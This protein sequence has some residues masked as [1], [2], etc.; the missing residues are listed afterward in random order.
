MGRRGR[1]TGSGI[2]ARIQSADR[3]SPPASERA[4]S[5]NRLIYGDNLAILQDTNLLPSHSVD[6]IYLDP[7]FNSDVEYNV[8]F[9][10]AGST[11][12]AAQIKAFDDTW[13]WDEA[14]RAALDALLEDALTPPAL[15]GLVSTLHRTLGPSPM[16]AYLVQMAARL[17]HL[18]RVLRPTGSIFLHCDPT[19]SHYL[20]VLLDT[21]FGPAMFTNE[22]VWRRT[23]SHNSSKCLGRIHDIIL[24]YKA[25]PTAVFNRVSRPYMRGHVSRRYTVQPDGRAKFTSGGNILTG[26]GATR[27]ESG[28]AWRGFAPAAKNR[29]WAIPARSE[30]GMPPEYYQLGTLDRLEAL[31][32]CGRIEIL[33]GQAWP[34]P[35]WYLDDRDGQALQDIW[36]AQPYTEGTVWNT[37][38]IID[39]DVSWLGTTDPERLGYPTQKP[40]GL[41]KR[42]IRLASNPGATILDPF[43]G[44]GTTIDAV[45]VLNREDPN[46][47]PR[48]W[49][50]IDIT[51]LAINLIKSRLTRFVPAA[52]YDVLGEPTDLAGAIQ[53]FKDDPFQFQYWAA[54]LVGARPFGAT[55]AAPK[56]GKKGADRGVD[57]VRH[58]VDA[59]IQHVLVQVKGGRVG[60]KDARDLRGTLAR[61]NAA[62]GI[63]IC[64]KEPTKA[65]R[66]EAASAGSYRSRL[67]EDISVPRLQIV[68]VAQLL[69]GGSPRVPNG[70]QLPPAACVGDRTFRR[71]VRADGATLFDGTQRRGGEDG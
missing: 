53:L 42:I 68:T 37:E 7:P 54:G 60:S 63:L 27:G 35:V 18:Q 33:P 13:R 20:K 62:I 57:A 25:S 21:I 8:L 4:Q 41:L 49:I 38:D 3:S 48:R 16:L 45:E 14:A 69:A 52:H 59:E 40:I 32:K 9:R 17:T 36:A 50:G 22:I 44:C 2:K 66:Q 26:P 67:D 46:S 11:E 28:A 12:A 61:E 70:I 55:T 6:L 19:A 34:Q 5:G 31:Y 47:T 1:S 56:V 71:A 64:L 30:E 58:F 51:H 10:R 15:A 29:H 39:A 65:M 23:G 24:F 43:C